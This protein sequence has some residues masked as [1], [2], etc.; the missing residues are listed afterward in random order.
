MEVDT[1]TQENLIE[2]LMAE[3]EEFRRLRSEHQ[4]YEHELAALNGNP[5]LSA[6]QHWRMS[7]LKKLKLM[8]KDRMEAIIRSTR[9]GVTA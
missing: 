6:D 8:A 9:S 5:S 3:N 4:G 2:R 1:M 7:E